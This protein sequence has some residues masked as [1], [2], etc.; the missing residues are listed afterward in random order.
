M[1]KAGIDL[2]ALSQRL[3][4]IPSPS[5]QEGGLADFLKDYLFGIGLKVVE[6]PVDG[7]R[8][9]ILATVGRA[10]RLLLCT[11]Q[12]TVP[13]MIPFSEDK[14]FIY[15]RGAC[16]AKGIMAVM[17]QTLQALSP[18]SLAD[19]GL[20]FLVGE[21]TDS[22]GA[23]RA[24]ALGLQPDFIIVGEPTDNKLGRGHK[25][26]FVARIQARGRKAHSGYPHLG[27]SAVLKLMKVLDRVQNIDFGRHPMLGSAT[28]NIGRVEG[29]VAVNV[30][31][32]R[33]WAEISVRSVG[34]R[35]EILAKIKTAVAGEA[36]VEVVGASE[37]QELY[38]L[39][40]F[41]T[42]VLSFSTDI[43]YLKSFG[44]PL[45]LGPGS[46]Q[47]AHTDTEKMPKSQMRE[48]V[49]LYKNLIERLLAMTPPGG[50]K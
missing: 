14:D 33:A 32:D 4:S 20:L 47:E 7:Q 18:E 35:P 21:E 26:F 39:P 36:E 34:P 13:P 45:L 43:P 17:I 15:G 30:V 5:G 49:D 50:R 10:P 6:Q 23:R 19:C 40:G 25:G 42:V 2:M 22:L 11:H 37:P 24:P 29:G 31:P 12:D 41:K 28:L 44:R 38:T 1:I 27:E 9:N 3:I 16:D 8:R 48:A 46:V